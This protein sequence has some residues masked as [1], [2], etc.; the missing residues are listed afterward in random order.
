MHMKAATEENGSWESDGGQLYAARVR[1]ARIVGIVSDVRNKVIKHS[2]VQLL[3][4]AYAGIV[5]S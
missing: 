4:F 5:A 1:Y 2:S 3:V